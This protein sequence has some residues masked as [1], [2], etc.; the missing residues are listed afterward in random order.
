MKEQNRQWAIRIKEKRDSE[1]FKLDKMSPDDYAYEWQ[2][3]RWSALGDLLR[4]E[5]T[6]TLLKEID[7]F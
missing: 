1:K 3:G 6:K 4:S 5:F 7:R 2:R